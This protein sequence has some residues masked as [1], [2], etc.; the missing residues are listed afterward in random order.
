MIE[1]IINPTAGNGYAAQIGKE[2]E[3]LLTQ[4]M[5]P[6][7]SH[8]TE[9]PGHATELAREAAA[10]GASTV[11]SIGGDGTL[12]ETAAGLRGTSA[13]PGRYPRRHGERFCQNHRYPQGLARRPGIHPLPSRAPRG[14]RRCQRPLLSERVRHGL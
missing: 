10:R 2:I 6:Y 1:L 4:R 8:L 9:H 7:T 11:I 3:Q 13:R 5:I 14:Y 12:T